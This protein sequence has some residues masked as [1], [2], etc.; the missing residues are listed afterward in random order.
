MSNGITLSTYVTAQTPT[1]PPI[2]TP[3]NPELPT[4]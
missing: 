3:E 1:T 2:V 4:T